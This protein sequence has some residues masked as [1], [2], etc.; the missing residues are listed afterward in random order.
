MHIAIERDAPFPVNT[1][2]H[3]LSVVDGR[4]QEL[5]RELPLAIQVAAEQRTAVVTENHSVGVQHRNHLED[6][7][8]TK[9][10]R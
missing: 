10:L 9:L 7:V 2:D 6:K 3:Q 5:V 1:A 4:V 8:L